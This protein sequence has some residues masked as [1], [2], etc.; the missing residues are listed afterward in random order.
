MNI[1]DRDTAE[2]R[3]GHGAKIALSREGRTYRIET[4]LVVASDWHLL[5]PFTANEAEVTI[6][7]DRAGNVESHSNVA[8]KRIEHRAAD[9][10][11]LT[12]LRSWWLGHLELTGYRSWWLDQL[13]A[14]PLAVRQIWDYDQS[15]RAVPIDL[16]GDAA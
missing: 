10:V 13:D 8:L 4:D 7:R 15:L 16:G 9:E 5:E 11:E 6:Y 1:Y 2:I 3:Q 12:G 14:A